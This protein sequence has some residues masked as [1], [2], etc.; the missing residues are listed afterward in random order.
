[1]PT[2]AVLNYRNLHQMK[3]AQTHERILTHFQMQQLLL[4][5]EE[6]YK[7][8][9]CSQDGPVVLREGVSFRIPR[10]VSVILVPGNQSA[11]SQSLSSKSHMNECGLKLF[12]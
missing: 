10:R 4:Y 5:L 9:F 3:K 7:S 2:V 11:E 12:L 6:Y 1:M 8:Q